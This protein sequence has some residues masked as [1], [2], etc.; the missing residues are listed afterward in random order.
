M[1]F[2]LLSN[3]QGQQNGQGLLDPMFGLRLS[4][5]QAAQ[6]GWSPMPVSQGEILGKSLLSA[7]QGIP[8]QQAPEQMTPYQQY[9]VMRDMQQDQAKQ[10]QQAAE[11]QRLAQIRQ[12]AMGLLGQPQAQAQTQPSGLLNDVN[13]LPPP[14]A[15]GMLS[16]VAKPPAASRTSPPPGKSYKTWLDVPESD[17]YTPQERQ[18]WQS[19]IESDPENAL[20]AYMEDK[21]A[22]RKEVFN[23]S[24]QAEE[25]QYSRAEQARDNASALR[26]EFAKNSAEFIK[27]RDATQRVLAAGE[28]PSPAGDLALIFNYMKVLDPGS[29]VREGEFANAQNS[30][31]VPDRIWA[32]YNSV[33]KGERLSPN[34]R[35]DFI[36]RAARLYNSQAQLHTDLR[37]QYD[38]I[39]QSMGLDP[40]NVIVNYL[41]NQEDVDQALKNYQ[42]DS[43]EQQSADETPLSQNNDDSLLESALKRFFK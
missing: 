18:A 34:Q 23:A 28:D 11:Q 10:Q 33:L 30:G 38:S 26:K 39:A 14:A 37:G 16:G 40:S 42:A 15:M 7:I 43:Y 20:R 22:R 27:Q 9:Q 12:N 19:R 41:L 21:A 17:L 13:Q 35:G 2:G 24:R 31:S 25:T 36:N 3:Q 5:A 1:P 4:A 6:S 29:T 32:A 8:Q